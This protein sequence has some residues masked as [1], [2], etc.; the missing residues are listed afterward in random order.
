MTT[1][2]NPHDRFFRNAFARHEVAQGFFER[3]LSAE[4]SARVDYCRW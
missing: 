3:Y 1:P 4:I 2:N